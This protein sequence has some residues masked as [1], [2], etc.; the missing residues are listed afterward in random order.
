VGL[1]S[2]RRLPVPKL[3]RLIRHWLHARYC[4]ECREPAEEAGSM[5]NYVALKAEDGTTM[6]IPSFKALTATDVTRRDDA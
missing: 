1:Y 6:V 3:P 4:C 2:E 5:F